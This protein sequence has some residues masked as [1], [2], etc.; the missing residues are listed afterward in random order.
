MKENIDKGSP[1]KEKKG[2]K[3]KNDKRK[4]RKVEE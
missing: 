3:E 2:M 1:K 4:E